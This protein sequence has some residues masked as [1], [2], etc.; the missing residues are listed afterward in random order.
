[1]AIRKPQKNLAPGRPSRRKNTGEDNGKK[2]AMDII[3]PNIRGQCIKWS[4][5]FSKR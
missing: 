2:G 4:A 1:M 3:T 5:I